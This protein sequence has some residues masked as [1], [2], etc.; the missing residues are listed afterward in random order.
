[1]YAL[2]SN[3]PR[4][5]HTSYQETTHCMLSSTQLSAFTGQ[6]TTH[7]NTIRLTPSRIPI[8]LL[9]LLL[10]PTR[11]ISTLSMKACLTAHSNMRLICLSLHLPLRLYPNF[12][13]HPIFPLCHPMSLL[14]L[15]RRLLRHVPSRVLAL[16]SSNAGLAARPIPSILPRAT[17]P[18]A[19]T[20]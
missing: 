20:A 4:L 8:C 16:P 14:L 11:H 5:L 3:L 19:T 13:R 15:H 2:P 12:S 1:M 7:K 17:A 10:P 18:A 6:P 9:L